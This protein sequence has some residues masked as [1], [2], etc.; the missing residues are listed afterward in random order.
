MFCSKAGQCNIWGCNCEDEGKSVDC[1]PIRACG[2]TEEPAPEERAGVARAFPSESPV[3]EV[4]GAGT[5]S[6]DTINVSIRF[7]LH[8]QY[9]FILFTITS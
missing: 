3:Y 4:P 7:Y 2:I 5:Y 8:K 9:N 1:L 6:M